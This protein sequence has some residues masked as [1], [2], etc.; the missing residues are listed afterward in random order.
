MTMESAQGDAPPVVD[1]CQSLLSQGYI[2]TIARFFAYSSNWDR[3]RFIDRPAM[4]SIIPII[5]G[6][7][8]RRRAKKS[9]IW[10]ESA[11]VS[12]RPENRLDFTCTSTLAL[13]MMFRIQSDC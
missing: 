2:T 5:F 7:R 10:I 3:E 11:P 8:L 1:C 4:R 12:A 9:A 13:A 6:C